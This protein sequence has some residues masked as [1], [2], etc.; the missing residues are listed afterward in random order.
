MPAIKYP[1]DEWLRMRAFR[2]VKGSDYDCA[3]SSMVQQIRNAASRSGL[4]ARI[5][6]DSRGV[7]VRLEKRRKKTCR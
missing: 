6:E 5:E 1:W 3:T 2:L 4:R 7:F